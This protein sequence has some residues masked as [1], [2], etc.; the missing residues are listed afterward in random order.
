MFDPV[1][2]DSSTAATVATGEDDETCTDHETDCHDAGHTHESVL[3]P[4]NP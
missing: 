2:R 4:E 3:P 1:A